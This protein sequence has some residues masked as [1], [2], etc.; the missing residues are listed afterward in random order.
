MKVSRKV[1]NPG[2]TADEWDL[3]THEP[4]L[5]ARAEEA[6]YALNNAF[7]DAVNSGLDRN[8]VAIA[9]EKVMDKYANTGAYDT[10]PRYV[11]ET[12]LKKVFG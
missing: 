7:T 2:L 4:A 12:L 5:Q 3:Y 11:L 1:E 6:A 8:A 9:V 10:E